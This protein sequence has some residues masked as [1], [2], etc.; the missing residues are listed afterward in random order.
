MRLLPCVPL[1]PNL[2]FAAFRNENP[3]AGAPTAVHFGCPG[4]LT[5]SLPTGL[6]LQFRISAPF[7][8]I[9]STK[10]SSNELVHRTE[11]VR[12]ARG[13]KGLVVLGTPRSNDD[14]TSANAY[15]SRRFPRHCLWGFRK[16]P[17]AREPSER[18]AEDLRDGRVT[19][20]R[21]F[22]LSQLWY[23]DIDLRQGPRVA[24]GRGITSHHEGPCDSIGGGGASPSLRLIVRTT[25][26]EDISQP[27]AQPREPTRWT[28]EGVMVKDEHGGRV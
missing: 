16:V 7:H 1:A 21:Q 11:L 18:Q 17:N 12:L 22:R 14:E 19:S 10:E 5:C 24:Q 3:R 13:G 27:L 25:R 15:T 26:F 20:H 6:G 9:G 2:E 4:A 23:L 8:R 28:P